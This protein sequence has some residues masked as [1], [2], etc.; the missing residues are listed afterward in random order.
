[1]PLQR[2]IIHVDCDCFYVAVEMRDDP[3]LRGL[4]VAVGGR[5]D[6]RGVIATCSYEARA[7]GVR[8]AM[9]SSQALRLCPQLLILPPDMPRYR[10]V[11]MAMRELFYEYT[12]LVEPLALD[13][14]YLD[15]SGSECCEGSA[16]RIAAEL[17]QR[18]RAQLGITVSAGVAPN[19]FLAKIASE[20]R[21]PDGLFVIR[22]EQVDSFV[23]DLPVSRLHGVG[24]ATQRRLEQLGI[25]R[26]SQ[27]R[28]IDP[29]Q[30]VRWFGRF[31]LRLSELSRGI[32]ERAVLPSRERKSVSV[33]RTFNEDLPDQPACAAALS[34][35]VDELRRRLANMSTPPVAKLFVKMKF[36]DFQQTTIEAGAAAVDVALATRL[37]EQAFRRGNRPVRLLGIGVRFSDGDGAQMALF[38]R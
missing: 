19:K 23:A 29:L 16:T 15:V 25:R 36:A 1:M 34:P 21:K 20:W 32:D 28:E 13:E 10:Q 11:A 35:L 24:P 33:E 3:R 18:I 30:L 5:A 9:A 27:L 22:P 26:C 7:F 6:R 14:A 2:K 12:E 38:E 17:R 4:P 8:S 31:G 37:C